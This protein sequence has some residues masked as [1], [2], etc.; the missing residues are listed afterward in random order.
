MAR[1]AIHHLLVVFA[2]YACQ[3]AYGAEDAI[4]K[5]HLMTYRL[6]LH[7]V[8]G[9]LN[10]L[11]TATLSLNSDS[12]RIGIYS[13]IIPFVVGYEVAANLGHKTGLQIFFHQGMVTSVFGGVTYFGIGLD[14]ETIPRIWK[15]NHLYTRIE[16]TRYAHEDENTFVSDAE[17]Q[18]N[19]GV[20]VRF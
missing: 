1:K 16:V 11:P 8:Y 3:N 9:K 14:F 19:W 2:I 20:G 17:S 13:M 18:A 5:Q 4:N 7:S 10:L 6:G 15:K 12:A